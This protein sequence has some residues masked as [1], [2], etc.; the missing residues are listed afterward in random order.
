MEPVLSWLLDSD[1]SIRWQVRRDVLR[2]PDVVVAAERARVATEGWGARLLD[3]QAPDG[4]WGGGPWVKHSWASS[5]ET[6]MLLRSFGLDPAGERTRK[7]I[8]LVRATDWGAEW[9][10]SPFFEGELEPC[11]NGKVLACGAYFGEAS[12]RLA[13]RLLGEQPSSSGCSCRSPTAG[14]TTCSGASTTC[15]APARLPI[16][17]PPRRLRLSSRSA[18]PTGAGSSRPPTPA[19]STSRWRRA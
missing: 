8:A 6:L 9:K 2:E 16:G 19:R 18:L 11:V 14:T 15:A 5:M 12:D 13:Q 4:H 10:H 7:A 3:L 1:P 17:A